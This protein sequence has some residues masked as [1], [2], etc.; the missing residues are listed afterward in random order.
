MTASLLRC[1][2]FSSMFF[3]F[4]KGR[5]AFYFTEVKTESGIKFARQ[6]DDLQKIHSVG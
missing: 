1:H 6:Q 2:L 3:F 5:I 4:E